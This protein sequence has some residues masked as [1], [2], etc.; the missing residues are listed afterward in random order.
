MWP[1]ACN[2]DIYSQS[3]MPKHIPAVKTRRSTSNFSRTRWRPKPAVMTPMLPTCSHFH[4]FATLVQI[5]RRTRKH[6]TFE[7]LIKGS[8][9]VG[10]RGLREKTVEVAAF[11]PGWLLWSIS[12]PQRTSAS[13]CVSHSTPSPML[14]G[15]ASSNLVLCHLRGRNLPAARSHI[16]RKG[17]DRSPRLLRQATYPLV[18]EFRLRW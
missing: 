11:L 14:H 18:Y 17:V 4:R 10:S 7:L 1:S 2:L 15:L 13:T 6:C 3:R 8:Y 9:N 12:H 5:C 16:L